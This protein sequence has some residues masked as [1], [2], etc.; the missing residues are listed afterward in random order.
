[1]PLIRLLFKD[2][3]T[4]SKIISK[5]LIHVSLKKIILRPLNVTLFSMN[6]ADGN[7]ITLTLPERRSLT[8]RNGK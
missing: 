4:N 2:P 6:H 5:Y 8:L 3:L 7:F 1:M